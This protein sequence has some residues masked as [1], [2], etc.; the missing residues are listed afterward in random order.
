VET[1]T[2]P[3]L[4]GFFAIPV[5]IAESLPFAWL[6]F[7]RLLGH[8]RQVSV[9]DKRN[10]DSAWSAILRPLVCSTPSTT[11]E[12]DRPLATNA[13]APV[14]CGLSHT[15]GHTPRDFRGSSDSVSYTSPRKP[16][17]RLRLSPQIQIQGGLA[18]SFPGEVTLP[19]RRT[20][21]RSPAR[22]ISSRSAGLLLVFGLLSLGRGQQYPIE[23][24]K[25]RYASSS[26]R[27]RRGA[28]FGEPSSGTLEKRSETH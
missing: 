24:R 9:P 16:L 1:F 12:R 22:Y 13:T 7:H 6:P 10:Y 8:T 27:S 23:S 17:P 5:P 19:E 2:P 3:A 4:P 26:G 15:L 20:I 14:A 25:G 11:P 18:K 21:S 28:V